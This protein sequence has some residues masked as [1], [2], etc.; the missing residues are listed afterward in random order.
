MYRE[1]FLRFGT[2]PLL[3]CKTAQS[4]SKS[5]ISLASFLNR[6]ARD[7]PIRAK[8]TPRPFLGFE[9]GF[10]TGTFM[11]ELTGICRHQ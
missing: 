10:T 3:A 8:D 5:V 9:Q 11:K 4:S 7:I 2:T 1:S 6:R